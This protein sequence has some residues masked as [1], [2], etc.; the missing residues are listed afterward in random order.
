LGG[1]VRA[2]PKISGTK[3][4][5]FGIQ[6]G[7]AISFFI[8]KKGKGNAVI[9]YARR[10]EMETREEKLSFISESK[11]GSMTFD[12]VRPDQKSNWINLTSNDWDDLIPIA[13]PKTKAAKASSQER[14]IFRLFSR[15]I[16]TQRDE[17]VYDFDRASLVKKAKHLVSV[18]DDVKDPTIREKFNTYRFA[19]HKEKVIDLLMRVTRVSVETMKIVE[20][21]KAEKR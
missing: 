3:H 8:K 12:S 13:D 4:N 18:Y 1:D 16:A 6:T 9:R 20:A 10:P 21:M 14:A 5:V 17:W 15:G 2:N 7:V 11:V 19:D